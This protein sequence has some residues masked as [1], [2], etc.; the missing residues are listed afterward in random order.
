MANL[1]VAVTR[2]LDA[3]MQL[4]GACEHG[5]SEAIYLR[6]P[7]GNGIE[8]H[9]D[10]PRAEWPKDEAGTMCR[11]RLDLTALLAEAPA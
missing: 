3:G 5:L 10:R 4:K 11:R 7:D 6:A 9:R 8:L 1:A 2:M